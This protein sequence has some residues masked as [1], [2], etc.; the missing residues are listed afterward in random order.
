[1]RRRLAL[2][3]ALLV[4]SAAI[5]QGLGGPGLR[6]GFQPLDGISPSSA[7][8]VVQATTAA[9][10]LF[11]DT[12]GSDSGPCT[13]TGTAACLTVNGAVSKI[14][15]VVRHPVI[16]TLG[17]GNFTGGVF[18]GFQYDPAGTAGAYIALVGALTTFAP[19]TGTATGTASAAAA[20]AN[21]P[22]LTDAT[23]SDGTQTW[24][25]NNLKGQ[26]LET[27]GGTG[28]GQFLPIASN[29]GTVV[30]LAGCW[31][32]TPNATTTYAIRD[33]G[34]VITTGVVGQPAN[35]LSSAGSATTALLFQDMQA[36]SARFS[37]QDGFVYVDSIRTTPTT[38]LVAQNAHVNVRRSRFDSTG[39]FPIQTRGSGPQLYFNAS[40][41]TSTNNT[42]VVQVLPGETSSLAS[43]AATVRIVDS[44]LESGS[45][46]ANPGLRFGSPGF[47]ISASTLSM[48]N[49]GATFAVYAEGLPVA[50]FWNLVRIVCTAGGSTVG[51]SAN[52]S[53]NSSPLMPSSVFSMAFDSSATRECATGI[54]IG[55]P[56]MT[57]TTDDS[58]FQATAGTVAISVLNGAQVQL[59]QTSAVSGTFTNQLSLDGTTT[60]NLADVSGT[61]LRNASTNSGVISIP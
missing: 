61:Q 10:A 31:G 55:G 57:L 4:G 56:G 18:H 8:N 12:T 44:F 13:G 9:L 21:G 25:A 46:G 14:P 53:S 1:M 49:S 41:A 54:R 24:T 26:I 42:V 6:S 19:A 3:V 39:G 37:G 52:I 60:A 28:A 7:P 20:C 58:T 36:G 43:T 38:G 45:S 48:T 17:T 23:L 59:D 27:T 2:A 11:V 33:W 51:I 40:V 32:V 16:V 15:K 35:Y 29:T 30:T 5:A 50:N 47:S 22:P 34:S